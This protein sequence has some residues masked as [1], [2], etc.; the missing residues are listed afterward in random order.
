LV[1]PNLWCGVP[2]AGVGGPHQRSSN[3]R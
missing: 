1:L 3:V 2:A